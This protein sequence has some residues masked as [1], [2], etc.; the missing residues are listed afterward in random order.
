MEVEFKDQLISAPKNT[1]SLFVN[2]TRTA[3]RVDV[4][5]LKDDIWGAL[6]REDHVRLTLS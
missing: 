3:K 5:H 4:K 2:Y 1:K 6:N